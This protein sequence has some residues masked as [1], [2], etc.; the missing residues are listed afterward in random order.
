MSRPVQIKRGKRRNG[1]GNP[2]PS[3]P[4]FSQPQTTGQL[5]QPVAPPSAASEYHRKREDE[6]DALLNRIDEASE[7]A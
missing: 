4:N 7:G 6:I 3:A 1:G 5:G 2:P